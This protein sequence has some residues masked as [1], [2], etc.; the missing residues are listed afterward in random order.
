MVSFPARVI[1]VETFLHGVTQEGLR[2]AQALGV[3]GLQMYERS[4]RFT[5]YSLSGPDHEAIGIESSGT[6]AQ[7]Q[8]VLV[9]VR[10]ANVENTKLYPGV[11]RLEPYEGCSW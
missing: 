7:G 4:R 10:K 9:F 3:P 6:F 1:G 11:S 5:W 2:F 8:C